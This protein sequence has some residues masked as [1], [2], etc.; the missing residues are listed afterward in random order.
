MVAD[1][2]LLPVQKRKCPC[3]WTGVASAGRF[4]DLLSQAQSM[5]KGIIL[6]SECDFGTIKLSTALWAGPRVI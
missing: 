5:R 6:S 2:P 1:W 3:G 4:A